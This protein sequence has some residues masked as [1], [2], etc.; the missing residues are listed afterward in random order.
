MSR[1]GGLF[2]KCYNCHLSLVLV[3]VAHSGESVINHYIVDEVRIHA[4][5]L[6]QITVP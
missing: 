6:T 2:V 1:L 4:R 5:L 3:I